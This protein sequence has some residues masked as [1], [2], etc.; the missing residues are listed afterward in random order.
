MITQ[1][2][3]V[4]AAFVLSIA[5]S[6]TMT[7]KSEAFRKLYDLN[8]TWYT[9]FFFIMMV[10]VGVFLVYGA[11][12]SAVGAYETPSCKNYSWVIVALVSIITIGFFLQSAKAH[13]T[14]T[15]DKTSEEAKSV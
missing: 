10:T 3:I 9:M 13:F 11:H 7:I 5:Y 2:W 4:L 8:G 14:Y 6:V 1:A 12:C 15:P